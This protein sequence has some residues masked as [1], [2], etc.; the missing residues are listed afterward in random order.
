MAWLLERLKNSI[1][2]VSLSVVVIWGLY[3]GLVR[4]ITKPNP[5]TTVQSGGIVYDIKIGFGG[6][7]RIP[8][9]KPTPIQQIVDKAKEIQVAVVK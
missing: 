9:I 6:C 3:A 7:A 1:I 4:P 2:Y 5:S 8:D